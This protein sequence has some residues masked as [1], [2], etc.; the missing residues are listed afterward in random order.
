M[1]QNVGIVV[2]RFGEAQIT[3]IPIP[4]LRDDYIL[5][6]VKAVAL[7]PTDWKHIARWTPVG[8]KIGCDYAGIV[9]EVGSAVTKPFKQGERIAG[10]VHGGNPSYLEDGAF[11]NYIT[12]KGDLQ[13]KIPENLSFEEAATLGA[14]VTTVAQAMYQSLKLPLPNEEIEARPPLL[15]YGGSTATGALAIQYAKLSGVAVV[16]TCSPRNFDYVKNLGADAVFDYASPTC[17]EDIKAYIKGEFAHVLDCIGEDSSANVC[18]PTMSATY[19]GTYVTLYPIVPSV[20]S[21]LNHTGSITQ[22]TTVAY[23]AMGEPFTTGGYNIPANP[24]DFTFAVRFW[25]ITRALLEEGK[26]RPHRAAIDR[27][28]TGWEGVMNGLEL[29]KSGGVSGEKLVFRI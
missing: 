20:L 5:I 24:A 14:G 3:D 12:A 9:K 4:K 13:I 18:I 26:L 2:H 27:C 7:N 17:A 15:I 22:V 23:T 1:S 21:S 11:S 19:P 25:E 16:T 29:L 28:G 8:G 6:Q 10:F